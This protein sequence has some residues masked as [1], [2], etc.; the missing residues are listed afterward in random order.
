MS[1]EYKIDLDNF[2]G[3][4]NILAPIA[5]LEA[6]ETGFIYYYQ[7]TAEEWNIEQENSIDKEDRIR[8]AIDN[9]KKCLLT[10]NN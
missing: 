10:L 9:L 5:S 7:E 8:M 2:G 4:L 6:T 1:N 3:F